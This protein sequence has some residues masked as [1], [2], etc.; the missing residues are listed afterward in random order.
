MRVPRD[1]LS[2]MKRRAWKADGPNKG[3]AVFATVL[4]VVGI[5]LVAYMSSL[6]RETPK[7]VGSGKSEVATT[8]TDT[9][10]ILLVNENAVTVMRLDGKTERMTFDQFDKASLGSQLPYEGSNAANGAKVLFHL[11][12]ATSTQYSPDDSFAASLGTP[13]ADGAAVLKIDARSED[14]STRT[15]VLRQKNSR[16]LKEAMFH[17]WFDIQTTAVSAQVTSTRW[18]YAVDINGSL[19]PLTELPDNLAGITVRN[20]ALWYTTAT[21]GEGLE[22][23]PTGPSELHRVTV[24]GVDTLVVRDVRQIIL[25]SVPGPGSRVAY[26]TDN[27]QSFAL[28][29]GNEQSRVAFGKQRPLLFLPND[30][31]L[32][33]DGYDLVLFDLLTGKTRKL[34]PLPEGA[35]NVFWAPSLDE[36]AQTE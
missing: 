18:I 5:A 34:G 25:T 6:K 10:A 2:G 15:I 31:I 13:K 3:L 27:G 23:P 7:E 24:D 9:S 16:P 11:F 29:V 28:S 12:R 22:S 17:G 30:R 1:I 4:V 32:L 8:A 20:G 36:T 26:T 21:M 14:I 35:V 33:R 19:K